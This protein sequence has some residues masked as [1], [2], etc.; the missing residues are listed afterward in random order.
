MK[1]TLKIGANLIIALTLL[2]SAPAS[3][4]K[5]TPA[6]PPKE[7]KKEPAPPPREIR[8]QP[9]PPARK[10]KKERRVA[11]T[12]PKM[13]LRKPVEIDN[14][15]PPEGSPKTVVI[16][17]GKHFDETCAV[18]FNGRLLKVIKR[19]AEE[20]SVRIPPKAVSDKFVITKSG[21]RELTLDRM[22]HVLRPPKIRT[23]EPRQAGSGDTIIVYGQNFHPG[24]VFLLGPTEMERKAFKPDRVELTVP[25]GARTNRILL[26]RGGKQRAKTAKPLDILLAAPSIASFEPGMGEA[27]S[28]I[29]ITGSNFEPGD[30]VR[31]NGNE[32]P[33]KGRGHDHFEVQVTKK[34]STGHLAVLGRRGRRVV[35]ADMFTVVRPPEIKKFA[36]KYGA[37]GTR[38]T[39]HGIGFLEG[40]QVAL[41]EGILTG[42]SLR[43]NQIVVEL[44]AGVESGKLAVVRGEKRFPI[45]G[46]FEV[47][48]PPGISEVAPKEGPA[49]TQV[50]VKGKNFLKGL[51]VMIA[52][53]RLKIMNMKL[54]YEVTVL[55]PEG[56]RSGNMVVVT[57]AGSA[58]SEGLF[59]VRKVASISGFSPLHGLAGTQVS[60]TGANFHEGMSV[61]LGD[62]ELPV[63][64]LVSAE[65]VVEIQEGA[66][67]DKFRIESYGRKVISPMAF[68]VDQP[69]PEIAFEFSP[70]K[71]RRGSEVTLTI[72]P[73]HQEIL[74]FFD[75]R[76]LPKKTL[77]GGRRVVVVIP[78]DARTGYFEVEYNDRRYKAERP[79]KV[80]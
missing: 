25:D 6:P 42:R 66:P 50:T 15:A 3:A 41:G 9:A 70:Q 78:S 76:P 57:R 46:S 7:V 39:L 59:Q 63:K 40:D 68:T 10:G 17:R 16:L 44:P 36:P 79:Y 72:D 60:I 31:I 74:V 54:P 37:P 26:H 61:H 58:R 20:M 19:S 22:F 62:A 55:I 38:I 30:H 32:M 5:R 56:V 80:R 65:V 11:P 35:S 24:D 14:F 77:Q 23:Y 52:G 67:S 34:H 48:L 53:K 73:P 28:I 18:R 33:I 27:G 13:D 69:K 49:G 8:R 12:G 29:K 21:F 51:E 47:I 2:L 43:H 4:Q 45:K 1:L 64:S 71:G 75:G